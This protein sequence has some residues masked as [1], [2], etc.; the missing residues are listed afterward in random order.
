MKS[1][2]YSIL[3]FIVTIS[4]S[5]AQEIFINTPEFDG[6]IFESD[7][8]IHFNSNEYAMYNDY[9]NPSMPFK[10]IVVILPPTAD[11]NLINISLVGNK[12][13][14]QKLSKKI[15]PSPP[16]RPSNEELI[17]YLGE[18]TKIVNGKNIDV[19]NS[20]SFYPLNRIELVDVG[21]MRKW[22]MARI[23][24]YPFRYN[25]VMNILEQNIGGKIAIRYASS[26]IAM[27]SAS[28]KM[29]DNILDDIVS[30]IAV[31]FNEAGAWYNIKSLSEEE[32]MPATGNYNYTI[33]TTNSIV[34]SST[35]LQKFINHKTRL[36]YLV[37]LVTE[38]SSTLGDG[39]GWGGGIGNTASENIRNWLKS[40][41]ISRNIRYVL[42]IGNPNPIT[43]NVPMKM[44]WPRNNATTYTQYKEAPSDLYYACLQGNWDLDNDGFFG[45]SDHDF[46]PGGVDRNIDVIVGRIPFYDN[47]T[48]LDSILQKIMDYENGILGGS[49]MKRALISCKP[50]D[51]YYSGHQLGEAIKNDVLNFK[52][53]PYTRIYEQNYNLN[54]PPEITPCNY[55]NVQNA[56]QQGYGFHIWQTHGSATTASDIFTSAMSSNLNNNT[57]SMVFQAACSNA[58][59]ETT[60]NLAYSLLLN[61]AISTVAATRVSWYAA[62][63]FFSNS[64]T[65]GGMAYRYSYKLIR[66]HKRCGDAHYG[67]LSTVPLTIWMNHC[68]HNLYGDPS[69]GAGPSII[70][71]PLSDLEYTTQNYLISARIFARVVRSATTPARCCAP[72][73]A[74]R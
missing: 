26:I 42:L 24:Y 55:T 38:T 18:N 1:I 54:P 56:W 30:S 16:L 47:Y 65:I 44:L 43:G 6:N 52:G 12:I 73:G 19:Y 27:Q 63:T 5:I 49:W 58:H 23:R 46:G 9:G 61:G 60:N 50:L 20:N 48:H 3:L 34:N 68:V 25:P 15:V 2:F 28:K 72:P 39:S 11:P 41:Y 66:E 35:N 29:N 57:P 74:T 67:M 33:I 36:G 32:P 37:D 59:P 8:Y 13:S 17:D 70:H 31:N 64:D 53:I 14:S 10:E 7:N 71:T 51:T 22:M 21:Y 40:R 4:N 69:I 62:Q 45:E